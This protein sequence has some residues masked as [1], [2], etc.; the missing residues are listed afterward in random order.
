MTNTSARLF[1]TRGEPVHDDVNCT[2]V[3]FLS[4]VLFAIISVIYLALLTTTKKALC[5]CTLFCIS[6]H[7]YKAET[8]IPLKY[9]LLVCILPIASSLHEHL[10]M[11]RVW[12]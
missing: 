1:E 10:N 3:F 5:Y 11:G 9:D 2:V 8:T 6:F 12:V 4:L 7:C